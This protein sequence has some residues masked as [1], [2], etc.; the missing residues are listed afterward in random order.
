MSD[1][2]DAARR[3]RKLRAS[4]DRWRQRSAEKQK[5]IRQLRITNRDLSASRDQ[6][7][8]RVK[9]LEQHLRALQ[10]A[11]EAPSADGPD[12]RVFL[13]GQI[14]DRSMTLLIPLSLLGD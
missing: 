2:G 3:A 8:A 14:V 1:E 12:V 7:K 13:G 11:A 9:E 10:S 4:R 5:Q 6:W